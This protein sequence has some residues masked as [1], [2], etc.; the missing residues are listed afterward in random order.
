METMPA[1]DQQ[2]NADRSSEKGLMIQRDALSNTVM[3]FMLFWLF[4]G[5]VTIGQTLPLLKERDSLLLPH[6]LRDFAGGST[7]ALVG[8]V[9]ISILLFLA[10]FVRPVQVFAAIGYGAVKCFMVYS[11][12]DVDR[13][14]AAYFALH[15]CAAIALAATTRKKRSHAN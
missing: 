5:Q 11:L 14:A 4:A 10:P 3:R 8:A 2:K 13:W 9:V 6:M 12:W 7:V 15:V 1:D